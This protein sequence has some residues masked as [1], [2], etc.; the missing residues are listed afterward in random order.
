MIIRL[1]L[2]A[3][4]LVTA[5]LIGTVVL[6]AVSVGVWRPDLVVLTVVAFAVADGPGTGARYGFMAGLAVDLL[7]AGTH[8][9][10][11]AALILLLI[12]Y[13]SGAARP[14]LSAT[15]LLGQVGLAA[16]A[17]VVAVVAYGVLAQV[18]EGNASS[19][20]GIVRSAMAT[21]LYN[22]VLAPFVLVPVRGLSRRLSVT[23]ATSTR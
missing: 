17:S 13:A 3:L 9:V 11:T 12:G 1:A 15:G 10:G 8:V 21:G 23:R 4:V 19:L 2:M 16:A 6:S 22:A 20:L 7:S 18:L 5:M 14:Y